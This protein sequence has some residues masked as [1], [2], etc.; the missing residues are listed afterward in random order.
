MQGE[1]FVL[2]DLFTVSQVTKSCGISRATLLRLEDRGLLH[3]VSIDPKSGYRYYDNH[4]VSR[5]LQIKHLLSIGLSYDEIYEYFHTN[6]TSGELLTLLEQ[7]MNATK[8]MYEEMQLRIARRPSL[9]FETI[10]LPEYICYTR[11]YE[12]DISAK[13]KYNVMYALFHEVVEK[14]LRP[15]S[16]A[17][18]FTINKHMDLFGEKKQAFICCIPLEPNSASS[19]C[20]V[21]KSCRAFACLYY[22]GYESFS[23]VEKRFAQKVREFHLHPLDYP[24]VFGIV[25]SYTA[26]EFQSKNYVSRIAVPIAPDDGETV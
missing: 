14:G 3:P 1:E 23:E 6:G 16:S 24:R 17:P 10:S 13:E 26:R 19:D 5:I 12:G 25:A 9:T 20:L 7:R 8:R 21:L 4:N 22:G 11:E 15:L 18:L 2:K